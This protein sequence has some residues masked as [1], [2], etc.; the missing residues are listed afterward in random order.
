MRRTTLHRTTVVAAAASALLLAGCGTGS[1]DGTAG[2]GTV[3]TSPSSSTSRS[4]SPSTSQSPSQSPSTPPST[5]PSPTGTKEACTGQAQLTA[6]DNGRT[7]CLTVGGQLRLTLDGS[8]DRPWKPVTT[9]GDA[10][11]AT[12]A[13]I[14]IQPGDA[15]AAYNAVKPGTEHLASTRPLCAVTTRPGQ[16]SCKAIQEW[17]VT[18]TVTK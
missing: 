6:A 16:V 5:S 15:L 14:A 3:S 1:D 8:K 10:L 13:G 7:V 18:V 4:S 11:E 12:N 9:K 2:S 17:N